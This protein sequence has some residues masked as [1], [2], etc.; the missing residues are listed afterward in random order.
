VA[1]L[2]RFYGSSH[3]HFITSSTYHRAQLYHSNGFRQNFV[4]TLD[5][6]R[7]RFRFKIIA[8]VLMPEHFHV[9]IWPSADADPSCIVKSL[10]QGTARFVLRNLRKAANY[11]G[12]AGCW[13]S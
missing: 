1:P 11:A 4:N 10:K 12:A 8:Y 2:H 7:I 13:S 6:L 9:L 5:E 3:L